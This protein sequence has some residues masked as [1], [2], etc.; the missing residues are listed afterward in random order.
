MRKRP[1][2]FMDDPSLLTMRAE[3]MRTCEAAIKIAK[4]KRPHGTEKDWIYDYSK[5]DY[6][7]LMYKRDLLIKK[8]LDY[9]NTA[10]WRSL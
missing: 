1:A 6:I 9:W 8:I 2:A 7:K 10:Q 5:P 3:L 4:S